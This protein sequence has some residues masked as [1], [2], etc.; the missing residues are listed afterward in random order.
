M[1]EVKRKLTSAATVWGKPFVAMEKETVVRRHTFD[2]GAGAE[3]EGAV[4]FDVSAT[5]RGIVLTMTNLLPHSIPAGDYGYRRAR[6]SVG[7]T[8][9]D[10]K[11]VTLEPHDFFRDLGTSLGAGESFVMPLPTLDEI[12]A[13]LEIVDRAGRPVREIGHSTIRPSGGER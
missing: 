10:G 6:L 9:R 1:P 13:R 7:G 4:R 8:G 5:S 2:A 12:Q 3:R 11:H